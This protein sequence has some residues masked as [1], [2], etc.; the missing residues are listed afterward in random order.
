MEFIQSLTS[1]GVLPLIAL[2][3]ALVVGAVLLF[4]GLQ[5]IG[6]VFGAVGGLLGVFTD[7]ISGGPLL[8]CGCLV[9]LAGLA[10]CGVLA[11]GLFTLLST[12]GTPQA[13]NI[14]TLFG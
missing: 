13:V 6:S 3:G 5:V 1:G 10:I 9:L 8:W 14:C 7:V 11:F 12:C 4:F 2:C